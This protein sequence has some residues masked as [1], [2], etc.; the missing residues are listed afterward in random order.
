MG[1]PFISTGMSGCC[2]LTPPTPTLSLAHAKAHTS[3]PSPCKLDAS[4]VFVLRLRT[5][6]RC[7]RCWFIAFITQ[8]GSSI[9]VFPSLHL[10][11]YLCRSGIL[12]PQSMSVE[13]SFTCKWNKY[14]SSHLKKV[15]EEGGEKEWTPSLSSVCCR[16]LVGKHTLFMSWN[17][18]WYTV[19]NT[20][21]RWKDAERLKAKVE[22][23]RQWCQTQ[24]QRG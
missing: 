5:A 17:L 19:R 6:C 11:S 18:L 3:L 16:F 21:H 20:L 9:S 7:P 1:G 22:G 23:L 14:D 8:L 2:W 4:S 15:T 10:S 12:E 24:S 13:P